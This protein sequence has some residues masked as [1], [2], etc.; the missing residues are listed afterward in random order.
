[1]ATDRMQLDV[2]PREAGGS[3]DARRL[4]TEGRIP[5]VLYGSGKEARAISV[6]ERDLRR[7]LGGDH[8]LHVILDIVVEGTKTPHH[9]VLKDYQLHATR[10]RLLHVDFHEV[11]LD[12]P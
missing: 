3:G 5:G 12:R 6:G 1:M 8:G 10:N 4:R 9:A 2:Q 11:R 7:V